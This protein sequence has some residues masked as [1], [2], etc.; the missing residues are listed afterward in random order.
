VVYIR[1]ISGF[2]TAFL[3]GAFGQYHENADQQNNRLEVQRGKET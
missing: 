1:G 3:R 2:T